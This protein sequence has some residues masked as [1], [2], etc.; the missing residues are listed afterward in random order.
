MAFV[1]LTKIGW[2]DGQVVLASDMIQLEDNIEDALQAHSHGDGN[3]VAIDPENIPTPTGS[4]GL[5]ANPTNDPCESCSLA[6]W[7]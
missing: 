3:V 1:L 2:V 4:V 7:S 5:P 6:K